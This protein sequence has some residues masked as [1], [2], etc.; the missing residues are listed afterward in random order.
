MGHYMSDVDLPYF[1]E[2][3]RRVSSDALW[4]ASFYGDSESGEKK[5][6]LLSLGVAEEKI[7]TFRLNDRIVR[8]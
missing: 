1:E 4:E 7:N 8:D 2:I 5:D 6:I 3:K